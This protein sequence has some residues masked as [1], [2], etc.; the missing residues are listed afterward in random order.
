MA[1]FILVSQEQE[2]FY[3]NADQ[4]RVLLPRSRGDGT[5][6][7]FDQDHSVTVDDDA[8]RIMRL[9]KWSDHDDQ[10]TIAILARSSPWR[11]GVEGR[12]SAWVVLA[13]VAG[14]SLTYVFRVLFARWCYRRRIANL[15]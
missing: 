15:Q 1:N 8:D 2:D 6:I 3:V 5:T 13:C 7:V 4:V 12:M 9:A 11:R 10:R 14:I